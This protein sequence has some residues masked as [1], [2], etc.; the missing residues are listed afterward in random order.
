MAE[1]QQFTFALSIDVPTI[2]TSTLIK[3]RA[4]KNNG[5]EKGE[6]KFGATFLLPGGSPD[7][8]PMKEAAVAALRAKWPDADLKA[9]KWPWTTGTEWADRSKAKGKDREM[10]RPFACI[11]KSRSKFAIDL[12]ILDNGNIIDLD[13]ET[14][15][16]NAR[17]AYFYDGVQCSAVFNFQAYADADGKMGV[18]AYLNRVLSLG[19]GTKL[20]IGGTSGADVF[21]SYRGRPSSFDPGANAPAP[22]NSVDDI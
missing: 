14:A 10:L 7:I 2:Y 5:V 1:K 20:K 3:A 15:K 6:A 4:F 22:G 19:K 17:D 12:S 9:V 13:N 11:L 16:N 8:K 21:S 18:T